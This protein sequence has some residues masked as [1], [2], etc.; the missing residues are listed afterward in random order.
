MGPN[1]DEQGGGWV[2]EC[3][4]GMIDT[5]CVSYL[6]DDFYPFIAHGRFKVLGSLFIQEMH[7]LMLIGSGL[8]TRHG[9]N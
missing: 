9:E 2:L 5:G 4:F 8:D 3:I 1:T 6:K 7:V